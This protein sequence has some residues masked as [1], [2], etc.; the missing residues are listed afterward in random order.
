MN[1]DVPS[2]VI[3]E[4]DPITTISIVFERR[5]PKYVASWSARVQQGESDY[6]LSSGSVEAMRPKE[7]STEDVWQRL[8]DQ[9]ESEAQAA[10]AA[11]APRTPERK[12]GLLSRLFGAKG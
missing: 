9:A 2:P 1:D 11:R 7:G 5:W 12:P 3:V 8:R 4:V 10:V 6:P